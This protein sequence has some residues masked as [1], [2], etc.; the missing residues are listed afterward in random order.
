VKIHTHPVEGGAKRAVWSRFKAF[1]Y[2]SNF[3]P[4]CE[5]HLVNVE[6]YGWVGFIA[7]FRRR[8]HFYDPQNREMWTA[9]KTVI[10]L[11]KDHPD[12][13]RLWALVSDYQAQMHLDRKHLFVCMA[14]MDHAAYRDEP[15][16][17]W[18]P[19]TTDSR[20]KKRDYR[21]HRYVGTSLSDCVTIGKAHQRIIR[22]KLL[23]RE[24]L[25]DDVLSQS[26]VVPI[27]NTEAAAIILKYEWL[28]TMAA[29]TKFCYAL[30]FNSEVLGVSC[31]S[32]GG[33]SQAKVICDIPAKS[34]CLARGA[35]VPHAPQ[36]A[37]S[38]LVRH[39]CRQAHQDFG[40]DVFFAYS[41]PEA[42]EMGTIYQA[43]GWE[44]INIKD[45]NGIKTSFVSPDGRTRFSSYQFNRKPSTERR[46]FALGWD[47][48]EGK[49]DF[50][51]RLGFIEKTEPTKGKYVWFEGERRQELRKH[52]RFPFLPYPKREMEAGS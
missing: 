52:C 4:A 18:K 38:F 30:K 32:N 37:G 20:A 45:S 28:G 13:F 47:G 7:S 10:K 2:A 6:G 29:G 46:F 5:C 8:G 21:S 17:G 50:L 12:Y 3:N 11:P 33:S 35:C 49:Y 15:N 16:S 34:I 31:F 41:D 9:H 19:S 48:I 44:Y 1:H 25:S 51:R 36:G 23:D 43:V 42:G 14:P 22:E 26:C 27:S 24:A 39:A 40:Y